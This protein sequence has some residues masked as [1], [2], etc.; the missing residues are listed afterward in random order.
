MREGAPGPRA[1][2]A[3]PARGTE[4]PWGCRSHCSAAALGTLQTV[5]EAALAAT[6]VPDSGW[7]AREACWPADR[8]G[9]CWTADDPHQYPGAP[10]TGASNAPRNSKGST[11]RVGRRRGDDGLAGERR[12]CGGDVRQRGQQSRAVR[13]VGTGWRGRPVGRWRRDGRSGDGRAGGRHRGLTAAAGQVERR[14]AW[15]DAAGSG[16]AG[17]VERRSAWR[18]GQREL[19]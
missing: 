10:Y 2:A 9:R 17:Q 14:R 8:C 1:P 19:G 7:P 3:G 16:A 6:A 5:W 15:R 13:Q 11:G 4:T 12:R 18:L